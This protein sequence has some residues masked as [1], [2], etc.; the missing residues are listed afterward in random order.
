MIAGIGSSGAILQNEAFI[1]PV[2]CFPHRGVNT[3]VCCDACKNQ[4][5]DAP[6]FQNQIKVGCVKASLSG[7]IDNKFAGCGCKLLNNLPAA[8]APDENPSRGTL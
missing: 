1:P 6:V 2:I 5:G 7:L 8:F 3:Y 4:M